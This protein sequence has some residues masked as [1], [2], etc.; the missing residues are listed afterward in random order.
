MHRETKIVPEIA[1][2]RIE[3]P[4]EA[5]FPI[6]VSRVNIVYCVLISL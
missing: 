3:P 4:F 2:M 1:E 5:S 6:W